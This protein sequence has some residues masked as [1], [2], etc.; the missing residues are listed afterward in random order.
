MTARDRPDEPLEAKSCTGCWSGVLKRINAEIDLRRKAR[1]TSSSGARLVPCKD[2]RA[3]TVPCCS[4]RQAGE[5]LPAP[6]KTAI[7][8]PEYF[9]LNHPTI[10]PYI[11]A[12][13]PD[14]LCEEY[15]RGKQQRERVQQ[16]LPLDE[17]F[18][19]PEAKEH[20]PRRER[21]AG[22]ELAGTSGRGK[23]QRRRRSG[24]EEDGLDS[25]EDETAYISNRWNGLNRAERY[26][27]RH[28]GEEGPAVDEDNPLPDLI[29]PIT[30]VSPSIR[31]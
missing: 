21:A 23:G 27:A 9:G 5:N 13:D 28:G 19:R 20:R 31:P 17:R 8:G 14:H 4:V 15:W 10:V 11:E 16:G 2:L 18:D 24:G 26:R 29:D 22:G 7:A 6:P 30:L 12:L 3:L 1:L 25:E